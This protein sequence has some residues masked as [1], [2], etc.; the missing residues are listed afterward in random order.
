MA[1]IL[2]VI[3]SSLS[4][5]LSSQAIIS[6]CELVVWFQSDH[7]NIQNGEFLGWIPG[8]RSSFSMSSLEAHRKCIS[9]YWSPSL[10]Q[11]QKERKLSL[12]VQI[13]PELVWYWYWSVL[14]PENCQVTSR[15]CTL[16]LFYLVQIV[17][18]C[19]RHMKKGVKAINRARPIFSH[20]SQQLPASEKAW[21]V[22]KWVK[23][24][25]INDTGGVF[26]PQVG[27]CPG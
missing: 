13:F 15:P 26:I 27:L 24:Q 1:C 22:S 8:V 9:A 5:S 14:I 25:D 20:L 7:L 11:A 3:F 21:S 6:F 18:M 19:I 10:F 17:F 12:L 16:L 4:G 23:H 2:I